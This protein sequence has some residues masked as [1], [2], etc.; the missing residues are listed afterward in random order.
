MTENQV[1]P[2]MVTLARES[3]EL[4]QERLAQQIG[5][6][7]GSL[8]RI[9]GGVSAASEEVL[10][11]LSAALE[12]PKEFFFRSD[13]ICGFGISELFHRKRQRMPVKQL[14]HLHA[15]M[16]IRLIHLA[17][18]LRGV[19]MN[20]P[21]FPELD[22]MPDRPKNIA[23]AVRAYWQLPPG[24]ILN[25]TQVIEDAGGI[26]IPLH[27]STD[28]VDAIS[29]SRPGLPPVFFVNM[30]FPGCRL[31]FTLGHELGHLIMHRKNITPKIESE[32]NEFAAEFLMPERE[33]R[34]HLANINLRTLAQLK[35]YWKVSMA[36]LLTRA[37]TLKVITERQKTNLWRE[38]S[39]LGYRTREPEELDIPAETPTLYQEIV[40]VYRKDLAYSAAELARVLDLFEHEARAMYYNERRGL[41]VI[42]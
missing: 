40:S 1:N 20:E 14:R 29:M 25:L 13:P 3:R 42:K 18:M 37:G 38:L 7:Q 27:L 39:A 35:P 26:I 33:I 15:K 21:H 32:A 17:V 10:S 16:N 34:P 41:R 30:K 19:E 36:A 11:A 8:S 9:E 23:R 12:Y 22:D 28:Y 24:P 31:R 2:R 4:T 5:I 6:G